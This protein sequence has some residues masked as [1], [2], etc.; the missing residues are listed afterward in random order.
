M[1]TE[2]AAQ[3][4]HIYEFDQ[5]D[6][7]SER[8][9]PTFAALRGDMYEESLLFFADLFQHDRPVLN[10]VDADYT[11]L[12]EDLAKHY[13]IP[14]VTGPRVAARRWACSNTVAAAS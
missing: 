7:K 12:N 1:A 13:G 6:E 9:F 14:D 5:L 3:W 2:F 4:L 11:F 8:H 10:I